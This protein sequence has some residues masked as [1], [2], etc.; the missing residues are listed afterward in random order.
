MS[1]GVILI[2]RS[3]IIIPTTGGPFCWNT[4]KGCDAIQIG[5]GCFLI[6]VTIIAI[7]SVA[8]VLYKESKK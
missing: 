3:P 8:V 6:G 1:L 2:P 5:L 7:V 4:E